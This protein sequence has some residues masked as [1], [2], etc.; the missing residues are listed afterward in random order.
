MDVS[1]YGPTIVGTLTIHRTKTEAMILRKQQFVG[2]FH[3]TFFGSGYVEEVN[4]TNCDNCN[5]FIEGLRIQF[6]TTDLKGSQR[7]FRNTTY[8]SEA[9]WGCY[10]FHTER[11]LL[12]PS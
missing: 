12:H 11:A 7:L 10:V 9:R 8:A 4:T 6:N 1:K 3:V 5:V 2:P